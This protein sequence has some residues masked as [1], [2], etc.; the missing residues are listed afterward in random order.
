[1]I[2]F[3]II[4]DIDTSIKIFIK[5]G[6]VVEGTR[7]KSVCSVLIGGQRPPFI[8]VVAKVPLKLFNLAKLNFGFDLLV[9]VVLRNAHL[10]D[11]LNSNFEILFDP[12]VKVGC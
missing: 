1:M 12:E 6:K 7:R 9:W 8:Q 11:F 3:I 5:V 10:G 2:S 4:V